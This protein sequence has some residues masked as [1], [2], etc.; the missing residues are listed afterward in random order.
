MKTIITITTILVLLTACTLTRKG[1]GYRKNRDYTPADSE[2]LG[3]LL[4]AGVGVALGCALNTGIDEKWEN[5]GTATYD[6]KGRGRNNYSA[7]TGYHNVSRYK[8]KNRKGN[9]MIGMALQMSQVGASYG[10]QIGIENQVL[11]L[12]KENEQLRQK[13][14]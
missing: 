14:N 6:G 7:R 4:G 9:N 8:T 10:R 3:A 5:Y 12:Q 13:S 11:R 2:L 1:T